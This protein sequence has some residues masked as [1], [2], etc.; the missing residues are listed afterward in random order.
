M[1][2]RMRPRYYCDHCGK[3]SGSPSYMRRHE[4]ICTANPARRCRM[5]AW[6]QDEERMARHVAILQG[7]GDSREDWQR[8]MK[9]LREATNNCPCCI[10]AAIRQS[11]VQAAVSDPDP[12]GSLSTAANRMFFPNQG[13]A[14]L[15]LGFDF[16]AELREALDDRRDSR[17]ERP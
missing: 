16:R 9:D 6:G 1:Q 12:D 7:P 2:T 5:C 11:G 4:E 15:M 13:G 10:L 8:K 17:E 3:G 14:D